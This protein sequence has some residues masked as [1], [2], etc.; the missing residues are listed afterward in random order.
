MAQIPLNLTEHLVLRRWARKQQRQADTPQ[1]ERSNLKPYRFS[2]CPLNASQQLLWYSTLPKQS[3]ELL[4]TSTSYAVALVSLGLAVMATVVGCIETIGRHRFPPGGQQGR[5][6]CTPTTR[7]T[8]AAAAVWAGQLVTSLQISC[9]CWDCQMSRQK[10]RPVF[11]YFLSTKGIFADIRNNSFQAH[12]RNSQGL[13][14]CLRMTT[15]GKNAGRSSHQFP[16][17]NDIDSICASY[18]WQRSKLSYTMLAVILHQ[19]QICWENNS[20]TLAPT[21]LL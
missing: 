13:W 1:L 9:G 10:H 21:P 20:S 11:G 3:T 17:T 15:F 7:T 12:N 2:D 19:N 16:G 5:S 4:H 8:A 14:L 6:R 18:P